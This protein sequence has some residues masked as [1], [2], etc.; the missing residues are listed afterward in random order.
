[1]QSGYT[2]RAEPYY[3]TMTQEEYNSCVVWTPGSYF[4]YATNVNGYII[5]PGNAYQI[6]GDYTP[7]YVSST[8]SVTEYRYC[9]R[10][11]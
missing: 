1:M 9:D 8:S 11:K 10:K 3:R 6:P 2:K 5:G 7:W 4:T